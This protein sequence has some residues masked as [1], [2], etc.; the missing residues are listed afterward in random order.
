[1]STKSFGDFAAFARHFEAAALRSRPA[2]A[3]YVAEATELYFTEV[4]ST[5][6]SRFRLL[7]LAP[8]TIARRGYLATKRPGNIMGPDAPLVDTG[9]LRD[10]VKK[11]VR[12]YTGRVGSNDPRMGWHE[13]GSSKFPPR[14]VFRIALNASTAKISDIRKRVIPR[15]LGH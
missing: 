15:I 6:G 10:S 2:I 7:A 11:Q 4:R 8:A 9:S 3:A 12:G 5:F 14:P 13:L 1:M